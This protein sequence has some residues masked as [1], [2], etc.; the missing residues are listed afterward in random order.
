MR[1]RTLLGAAGLAALA[2]PVLATGAAR[3]GTAGF[4]AA[5]ADRDAAGAYRLTWACGGS[6]VTVTAV[7]E[8]N[9]TAGVAVGSGTGTLD[10]PAGALPVAIRWY[11][12][13]VA[14]TGDALVVADRSLGFASAR[15]FRDVGGYRTADGRWVRTGVAY[16]SNSL[17]SLTDAERAALGT[18]GV[19]RD[20]DLR[21]ASERHDDPDR[22][23]AGVAYQVADVEDVTHGIGCHDGAVLTLVAALALGL[24]DGTGNLGQRIAYPFMVDFTGA[25]RAYRGLLTALATEPGATVFHCS[26]GK[27][28]TGWGTAVLLTAL[29]VPRATVEADYLASNAYLGNPTAVE[30]SWLRAAFDEADALYGGMDGYLRQGLDLD[31]ATIGAL[32]AKFL[33]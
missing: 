12:R 33:A 30:P 4:T 14:D 26:S 18:L 11:F 13:L 5:T 2:A 20:V 16:R 24:L 15:N 7:T 31:D 17:A 22:I 10:V 1:R 32:R 19:T 9:A 23:P 6:R 27:D 3:A 21:N 29:G 8:P 28:R 25:D